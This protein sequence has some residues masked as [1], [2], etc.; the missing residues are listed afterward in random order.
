MSTSQREHDFYTT[1]YQPLM[2]RHDVASTLRRRCINAMCPLV[3]NGLCKQLY[4]K[5]YTKGRDLAP[6]IKTF[7]CST[8]LSIKFVL[9][10]NLKI[11]TVANSFLLNSAEH[12]NL[13]LYIWKRQLLLAFSYSLAEKISFSAELSMNFF[14]TSGFGHHWTW[15]PCVTSCNFYPEKIFTNLTSNSD[16][17]VSLPGVWWLRRSVHLV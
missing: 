10:I 14:I 3:C 7:S 4:I 9:L 15:A 12:E 6:G 2:Q 11:L 16:N 17:I 1:S 13:F 8:Q 5:A